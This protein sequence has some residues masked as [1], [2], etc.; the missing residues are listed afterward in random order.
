LI[1]NQLK[2]ENY[3]ICSICSAHE[4]VIRAACRKAAA[5]GTSVLIESTSN[6]VDQF[7]GYTGMTPADFVN[8]VSAIAR[9]VELPLDRLILGGDHLGPNAWQKE[10]AE[11]AMSKARQLIEDY[12]KAGYRK[13]H[14]DTSMR[15]AD[16]PGEKH[17]PLA[18]EIIARRAVALCEVAEKSADKTKK[19]VYVIGTDV[20]IPGG[21]QEDLS[22]L[23]ITPVPEVEETIGVTKKMIDDSGLDDAWERV[24]AVVVQPG[25]EFADEE[26]V[27]YDQ[28]KAEPLSGYIKTENRLVYEAHST[29]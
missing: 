19:P 14:L 1:L 24:L 26:I 5:D 12:V 3:G 16:D 9:S 17:A 22:Q 20:P 27:V 29:D 2:S 21:A 13:I 4:Y 7:G 25:V 15:C 18:V 8:Y 6:Q 23:R 10:P 11:Q 28:K